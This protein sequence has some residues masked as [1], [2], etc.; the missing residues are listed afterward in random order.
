MVKH[1]K[2]NTPEK[3][4]RVG[5]RIKVASTQAG[6][7]LKDLAEQAAVSPS[8]IY[9][10]VRGITAVPDPLLERIASVTRVHLSFFDPEQDARQAFA[11]P[12]DASAN[13]EE[14]AAPYTD[15]EARARFEQE[16][17]RARAIVEAYRAP[18]SGPASYEAALQ[19]LLA[20]S[21]ALDKGDEP[22]TLLAQIGRAQAENGQSEQAKSTLLEARP[23]PSHTSSEAW[24]QVTLDLAAVCAEVGAMEE[25]ERYLLEVAA[26]ETCSLRWAALVQLGRERTRK[27]D[28]AGAIAF[29]D[30]SAQAVNS[31][32]SDRHGPTARL[33]LCAAVGELAYRA[34]DFGAGRALWKTSG[35]LA[36]ELAD[37][38][39]YLEAMTELARSEE[40]CGD[41]SA[42]THCLEKA[43]AVAAF[44]PELENRSVPALALLSRI[45]LLLGQR[46]AA[47]ECALRAHRQALI[48]GITADTIAGSLAM[49]QTRVASGHIADALDHASEALKAAERSRCTEEIAAARLVRA[50]ALYLA[51]EKPDSSAGHT[52]DEALSEAHAALKAATE[53]DCTPIRIASLVLITELTCAMRRHDEAQ[54]TATT[55]LDAMNERPRNIAALLGTDGQSLV[56]LLAPE[57]DVLSCFRAA[58]RVDLPLLEWRV[59][60]LCGS[61]AAAGGQMEA[62]HNSYKQASQ[63]V[64]RIVDS[65]SPAE[66]RAFMEQYVGI[67]V[68]EGFIGEAVTAVRPGSDVQAFVQSMIS[69]GDEHVTAVVGGATLPVA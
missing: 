55:L 16:Y 38:S 17:R 35:R 14:I 50:S 13:R 62:A 61:L 33:A 1:R 54:A 9:Q 42:A 22:V 26:A 24:A 29:F 57:I 28:F 65:L 15:A 19:R 3:R 7:S 47:H 67:S 25:A 69:S 48:T 39:A 58:V 36:E 5:E 23:L 46:E 49:A 8:V 37:A 51:R 10:Y 52:H 2:L 21:R 4:A 18:R 30:R 44:S 34:G 41:L 59:H 6:L 12:V 64:S 32:G 63:I 68:L 27:G 45:R 40:A 20:L 53:T 31:A 11:L 60:V 56:D 66:A 43:M